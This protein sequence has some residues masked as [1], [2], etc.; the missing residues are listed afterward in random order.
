MASNST[1]SISFRIDEAG[2]FMKLTVDAEGLRRVMQ[3][4]LGI[5]KTFPNCMELR[6]SVSRGRRL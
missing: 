1:I 5:V 2:G 4:T 6:M 3:S